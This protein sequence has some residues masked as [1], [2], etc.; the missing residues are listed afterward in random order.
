MF[1]ISKKEINFKSISPLEDLETELSQISYTFEV[2]LKQPEFFAI[3]TDEEAYQRIANCQN[4]I[5]DNAERL[6]KFEEK[7]KAFYKELRD[8]F[9]A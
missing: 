1:F 3:A 9:S 2:F 6:E 7:F 5:F 8:E 4:A